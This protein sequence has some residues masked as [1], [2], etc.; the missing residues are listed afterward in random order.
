MKDKSLQKLIFAA[1]MVAIGI[2]LSNF[3]SISYPPNSTIIRFGIG[4]LPLIIVSVIL[5]PKI[6]F[7]AA[8]IQDI[9]GYFVYM[10]IYGFASGPFFPGFTFNSILYGVLPGIIANLNIKR[11]NLF[12]FMNVGLLTFLLF[13]GVWALVEIDF[14][15]DIIKNKLSVDMSFNPWIIYS[16]LGIGIIGILSGYVFIYIRRNEDDFSQRL[17]FSIIILQILVSLILTPIWVTILY[18]SATFLPQ[19]PLRIIK[20]PLEVF[21]YSVLLIRLIKVFKNYQFQ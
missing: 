2:V 13:L 4:Y 21:V 14:I 12:L 3:V 19:L 11:K 18:S 8:I 20:T 6:G 5:G 16:M 10:M 17:I 9:L 1:L 15:I 7:A